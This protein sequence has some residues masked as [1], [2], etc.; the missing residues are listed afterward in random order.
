M[1]LAE[2]INSN[3]LPNVA[4]A[5]AGGHDA[6]KPVFGMTPLFKAVAEAKPDIVDFLLENG[7]DWRKRDRDSGWSPLM[8]AS[9]N[10]HR[11]GGRK[12]FSARAIR[13]SRRIVQS[14]LRAGASDPETTYILGKESDEAGLIASVARL[15]L[16]PDAEIIEVAGAIVATPPRLQ[17][18]DARREKNWG[19]DVPKDTLETIARQR[20][21]KRLLR[22]L[23]NSLARPRPPGVGAW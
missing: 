19:F 9:I 11:S 13:D 17:R 8:M 22:A 4:A 5:I 21:L 6:N 12:Y 3:K 20:G 2:A 16:G 18:R 10:C 14:L 1:N 15:K 23:S 7:A